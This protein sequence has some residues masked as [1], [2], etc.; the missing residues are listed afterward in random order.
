[1][2]DS[3]PRG[4][5]ILRVRDPF[6]EPT[7][8]VSFGRQQLRAVGYGWLDVDCFACVQVLIVVFTLTVAYAFAVR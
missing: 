7:A 6:S 3:R 1:M 2:A 5:P 4:L 8:I